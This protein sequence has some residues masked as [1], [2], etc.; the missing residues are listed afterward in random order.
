[1]HGGA[2]ELCISHDGGCHTS[3][4]GC[5]F[6]KEF[7]N[8]HDWAAL[9]DVPA[10]AEKCAVGSVGKLQQEK[11]LMG[12]MKLGLLLGCIPGHFGV[13][14]HVTEFGF[15]A[16]QHPGVEGGWK[17]GRCVV[18]ELYGRVDVWKRVGEIECLNGI[19]EFAGGSN[20]RT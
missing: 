14:I 15:D 5:L 13:A 12:V 9:V 4:P 2:E 7:I 1:M 20:Y 11:A 8:I 17:R 19:G 10:E 16:S 3:P 18:K 6:D